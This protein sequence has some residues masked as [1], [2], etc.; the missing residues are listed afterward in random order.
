MSCRGG[1]VPK[2]GCRHGKTVMGC[3]VVWPEHERTLECRASL[4]VSV[5]LKASLA[6]ER[7]HRKRP[8][9]LT[10]DVVENRA[11]LL[12]F[13]AP[14]QGLSETDL[15]GERGWLCVE[16]GAKL[17][18][19]SDKLAIG[20]GSTSDRVVGHGRRE[21]VEFHAAAPA[22][23]GVAAEAESP[24]EPGQGGEEIGA[25]WE[26]SHESV[27]FYDTLPDAR[28]TVV[29]GPSSGPRHREHIRER[30]PF[31]ATLQPRG[32]VVR[33]C[34]RKN[35]RRGDEKEDDEPCRRTP[36]GV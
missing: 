32:Q 31:A 12:R 33:S 15:H 36:S 26:E 11:R 27:Q 25:S 24:M 23:N 8:A 28:P 17:L 14:E 22:A 2:T 1:V 5:E 7:E 6:D 21:W 20:K 10:H 18:R 16:R 3:R 4:F 34:C 35:C 19:C 13:T 30:T 29:V 9:V